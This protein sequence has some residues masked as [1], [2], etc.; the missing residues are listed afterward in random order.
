MI[1]AVVATRSPVDRARQ[2]ARLVPFQRLAIATVVTTLVLVAVGG[3]VRATNSGLACPD[4]PRCYGMWVPP[5]DFHIWLE[6]SHRLIAGV[7]GI[8]V[9]VLGVWAI[10]RFRD[11]PDI[12][13]PAVVAGVF[14][15]AQAGLGAVVIFLQLQAEVV[16]AHLGMAMIVLAALAYL[17]VNVSLPRPTRTRRGGLDLR[18]ARVSAVVAAVCW[19]QIL[20]GGHVTGIRAWRAFPA[21]FPTMGGRLVPVIT[22]ERE[23]YHAAHRF[24]AYLLVVVVVGLCVAA[25]RHR[26][27][28]QAAGG[29]SD[30]ERWLVKLPMWAV[31]LVL[32]QVALGVANLFNQ[33]STSTVLPHLVVASWLWTI[34]V[35]QTVLAYR[36]APLVTRGP[37]A[38][39][40][41]AGH[42]DE[43]RV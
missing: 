8:M 9:A 37:A 6:H 13:W 38:Q 30:R 28:R 12:L 42:A 26:R 15:V 18:F 36:L 7:V 22:T 17:T 25:V 40:V 41:V 3:A 27:R 21:E 1:A 43:A 11:R 29:W 14:V 2:P 32:V 20:V 23:L 35:V 33:A 24:L 34:L 4:W 31:V 16:T 39:P 19:V 10:A 5:A